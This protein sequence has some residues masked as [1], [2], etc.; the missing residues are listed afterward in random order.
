MIQEY[1]NLKLCGNKDHEHFKTYQSTNPIIYVDKNNHKKSLHILEG[2]A[3][4]EIEK[5]IDKVSLN[6]I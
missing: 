6:K 2:D 4:G 5:G 3:N 1:T